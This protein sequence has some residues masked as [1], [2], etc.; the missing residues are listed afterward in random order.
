MSSDATIDATVKPSTVDTVGRDV[1]EARCAVLAQAVAKQ[2]GITAEMMAS[3]QP[4]GSANPDRS[5]TGVLTYLQWLAGQYA[6]GPKSPTSRSTLRWDPQA[7]DDLRAALS[8]EPITLTL[9][10]GREVAVHPKSLHA[11]S[12]VAHGQ[13]CLDWILAK[14]AALENLTT[15]TAEQL[16]AHAL[17]VAAE[18]RLVSEFVWICIT[19]GPGLPWREEDGAVPEPPTWLR[20]ELTPGDLL[21]VQAAFEE[22]NLARVAT[23][24]ARVRALVGSTAKETQPLAAFLGI[25][26]G[27]HGIQPEAIARNWSVCAA[28]ASALTRIEAN[29][30][31]RQDAEAQRQPAK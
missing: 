5:A 2:D 18:A 29:E 14:R 28:F 10:S 8:A 9:E 15:L 19:A 26:A 21:R 20:D 11:L 24:S 25:V 4:G 17:S 3:F 6:L 31:A 23:L 7:A 27:E 16:Q 22:C 30:Q 13:L 1:L 12:R